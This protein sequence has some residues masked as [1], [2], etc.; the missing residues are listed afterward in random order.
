SSCQQASPD[1]SATRAL[2]GTPKGAGRDGAL[3]N[4]EP[5]IRIYNMAPMTRQAL[6]RWTSVKLHVAVVSI[7]AL[8]LYLLEDPPITLALGGILCFPTYLILG[9]MEGRRAP[10]WFSPLSFYFLWYS[11]DLGLSAI[12]IASI[13]ASGEA[14]PFVQGD[15]P[16]NYIAVAY[17]I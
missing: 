14:I 3:R 2:D 6:S 12:Y 5:L 1:V 17:V 10:L 8:S 4:H 11:V 16:P 9:I 15:V 7:T 13:I